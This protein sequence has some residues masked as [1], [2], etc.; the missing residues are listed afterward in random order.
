LIAAG[1]S[2]TKRVNEADEEPIATGTNAPERIVRRRPRVSE[3]AVSERREL[4]PGTCCPNCGVELVNCA[5]VGEDVSEIPDM[6]AAQIKVIETSKGSAR[7]P[8]INLDG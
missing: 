5:L 6:I 3:K 8:A 4:D 1:E 2:D 7:R